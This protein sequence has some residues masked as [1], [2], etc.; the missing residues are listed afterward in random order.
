MVEFL[1]FILEVL[2]IFSLDETD[3]YHLLFWR[4]EKPGSVEFFVNVND[5]FWWATADLEEITPEDVPS[6]RQAIADVKEIDSHDGCTG[7]VLWAARKR[8]MRPQQPAYP[9]DERIR[10]LFDACGPVRTSSDEG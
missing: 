8:K 9:K 4:C 3:C 7:F 6:M 2:R 10:L 5:V 1:E